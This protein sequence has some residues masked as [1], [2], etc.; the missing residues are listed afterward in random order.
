MT[1]R[2]LKRWLR[3]DLYLC[4]CG[5]SWTV[6]SLRCHRCRVL[7]TYVYR[8]VRCIVM[9]LLLAIVHLPLLH[10]CV[11]VVASLLEGRSLMFDPFARL[12]LLLV[13]LCED[14]G[15]FALIAFGGALYVP[16]ARKYVGL[17][18]SAAERFVLLSAALLVPFSVDML[19]TVIVLW[20]RDI[21]RFTPPGS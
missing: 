11:P 12:Y 9:V 13:N 17:L 16:V 6:P 1:A 20:R 4:E 21:I 10:T 14:W 5:A 7:T 3:D 19:V 8:H 2:T 18:Q 15:L